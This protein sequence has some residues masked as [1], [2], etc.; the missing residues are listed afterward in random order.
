M[1]FENNFLSRQIATFP[2]E[3]YDPVIF[4]QQQ[5]IFVLITIFHNSYCM[6]SVEIIT[7]GPILEHCILLDQMWYN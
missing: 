4:A 2:N 7:Q 5:C 3:N 6:Q 1:E